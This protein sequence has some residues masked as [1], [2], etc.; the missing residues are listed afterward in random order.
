MSFMKSSCG[1][2][3]DFFSGFHYNSFT[4][5]V[6]SDLKHAAPGHKVK[7]VSLCTDL[8]AKKI[9]STLIKICF[10]KAKARW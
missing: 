5:R 1:R 10:T 9:M 8:E 3:N 7:A 2:R 6:K 4:L